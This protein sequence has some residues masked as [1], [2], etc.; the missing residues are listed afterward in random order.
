MTVPILVTGG[1]GNI[2]SHVIPYLRSAGRDVRILSRHRGTDAAG[3]RHVEADL[4][5]GAGVAQALAGVSTMLHLAGGPKGDDVATA[6]LVTLARTAGVEHLILISVVGAGRMPIGYF[7][8]KA[9][10][11]RA[12]EQSGI[13]WTTLRAAQL[14]DFV[15]PVV[16]GLSKL[17]VAPVPRS[18]RLEPVDVDA[19]AAR[20]AEL[21]LA[22]P[23][24]LVADIAGPEVLEVADLVA[25]YNA[26]QGRT[27]RML[28]FPLPGATGRAY[29][30]GANL[31]EGDNALRAGRSWQEY[32]ARLSVTA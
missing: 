22:P 27:R 6:K 16:R 29:R 13:G 25:I 28:R 2:G 32:L 14:H 19:V 20:L 3:I 9:A 8:M 12:V 24:G 7:R 4:A 18:V 1:T 23:A 10:A 30:D 26:A 15:L 11:E 21:T 31:A 17:P 5:S